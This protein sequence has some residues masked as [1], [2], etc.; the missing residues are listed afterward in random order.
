MKKSYLYNTVLF[1]SLLSLILHFLY[2]DLFQGDSDDNIDDGL[3][4]ITGTSSSVVKETYY[5]STNGD[6]SSDGKSINRP[7]KT[8]AAALK[9][10]RPGGKI[11]ILSG[12]Y[13]ESLGMQKF[14]SKADTITIAGF[15]GLP[16]IDG[17]KKQTMGIFAVDCINLIFQNLQFQ[18]FTDAGLVVSACDGLII[19]NVILKDNGHA[20]KLV[21]WEFE[22]YGIHVENSKNVLIEGVEAYGNGPHPKKTKD[23]LLGTGINT[24]GNENVIIRN[25]SSH[26]NTGGG[27]LI[28]DSYGVLA[29]SNKLYDNDGDASADE[30]WD[31]GL[32]LDGGSNVTLKNN[33]CYNNLGAGIEVSDEDRQ[34]PTGYVLEN[35]ICR[36]N[37]FGIFVWNFG[38]SDWPEQKVMKLS[39]NQFSGNSRKD[40]WIVD[41]IE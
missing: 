24:Y 31:A 2:C 14:G 22:G 16:V 25:N 23:I 5:V 12:T 41:W 32:W 28:E 15:N 1:F 39:G 9:K 4:W 11:L 3:N 29:E 33:L 26:H 7:L 34:S 8:L 6:D 37:Y 21:D 40:I 17:E 30:W 18:N 27:L 36:D 19:K 20:V 10:I 38:S 35:N 13:Y